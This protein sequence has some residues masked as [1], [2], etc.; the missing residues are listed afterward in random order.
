MRLT[1]ETRPAEKLANHLCEYASF[2]VQ[3]KEAFCLPHALH[4][5]MKRGEIYAQPE[6]FG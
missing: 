6:N 2:S 4:Q 1:G 5:A 3:G